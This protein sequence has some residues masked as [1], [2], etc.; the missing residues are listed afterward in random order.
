MN[1]TPKFLVSAASPA[2]FPE[3]RV[4][5]IAVAG[6]SNVGKSSFLNCLMGRKALARV[7]RTPGRTR[8]ANFFDTGAGFRVVDLPGYGYAEAGQ[9]E[10]DAWG[11]LIAQ[12]IEGRENL[13]LILCLMDARRDPSDADRR[14]HNWIF[15]K[16]IPFAWVATKA[17]KVSG[18]ALKARL[19]S[20]KGQLGLVEEPFAFSSVTGLGRQELLKFCVDTVKGL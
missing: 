12:Y 3:D 13:R 8:L 15:E 2:Q 14:I 5:E 19:K 7:S 4:P 17:D 20:M 9:A 1:L 6:R 18:T 11:R 10:R 16:K